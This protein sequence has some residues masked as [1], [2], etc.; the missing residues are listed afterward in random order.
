MT[1]LPTLTCSS[2]AWKAHKRILCS[3]LPDASHYPS[4]CGLEYGVHLP[5]IRVAKQSVEPL[6]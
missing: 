2:L 5:E 1:L 4:E 6:F 3:S